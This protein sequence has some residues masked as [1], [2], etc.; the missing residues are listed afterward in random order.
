R[1]WRVTE[2][3]NEA[4]VKLNF[5]GALAGFDYNA[6]VG[7]RYVEMETESFAY[8]PNAAS[9]EN[10]NDYTLPSASLNLC[11]SDEQIVR[12]GIAKAISR[13]PLDEMRAGQFIG[14][15]N[16]GSGGNAGNPL[17]DPFTSDQ[18]DVAYEWYFAEE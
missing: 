14:A 6:N 5:E 12:F 10:K 2:K 17:L 11:M 18:I 4:F 13:P 9:I 3:N 7:V 1:Y 8:G 15:V 16:A